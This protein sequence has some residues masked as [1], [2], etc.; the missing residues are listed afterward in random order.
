MPTTKIEWNQLTYTK[1]FKVTFLSPNVGGH[2]TTLER[3]TSWSPK[4]V[5][6][7]QNCQVRFLERLNVSTFKSSHLTLRG[8]WNFASLSI[9]GCCCWVPRKVATPANSRIGIEY[10]QWCIF[11]NGKNV[12]QTYSDPNGGGER[13]WRNVMN[14]IWPNG[15]IFQQPRF[16]WNFRG[17]ISLTIHHH[18]GGPIGRVFGRELIWPESMMRFF[19]LDAF[20]ITS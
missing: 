8:P 7:S 5:T 19:S 16:P 15:I 6:N 13:W 4:K 11:L 10:N 17:P 12:T 9:I 1:C 14:T 2:L 20:N 3:V 18:L